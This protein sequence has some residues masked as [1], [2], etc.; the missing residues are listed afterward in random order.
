[1]TFSKYEVSNVWS[2]PKAFR[3]RAVSQ[4]FLKLA[5]R[6]L[7]PGGVIQLDFMSVLKAH[8]NQSVAQPQFALFR[9]REVGE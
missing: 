7:N 2:L 3:Q 5:L 6:F 1:M 8:S 9:I 4:H